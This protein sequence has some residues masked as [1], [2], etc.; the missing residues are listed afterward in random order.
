MSDYP[1]PVFYKIDSSRFSFR[2]YFWG[3]KNPLILVIAAIIKGC[4][5]N[6]GGSTDDPPVESLAPFEV[7]EGDLPEDIRTKFIPLAGELATLG[8]V[9]PIFHFIDDRLN[10]ATYYWATFHHQSGHALAR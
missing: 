3:S 6:T 2:E 9:E 8:F 4:R 1:A 10:F 7:A 5:I